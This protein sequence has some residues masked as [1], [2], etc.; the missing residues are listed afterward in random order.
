M[1][2][3]RQLVERFSNESPLGFLCK[4]M[5]LGLLTLLFFFLSPYKVS[6]GCG[7]IDRSF[8]GYSFINPQIIQS[9][10]AF[11]PFFLDFKTIHRLYKGQRVEQIKGN[12]QEWYER[13][14]E[15]P[16]IADLQYIIYQASIDEM[17]QLRT[18]IN[19]RSIPLPYQM[20][21]NTFARYL[22]RNKCYETIDYLIFAKRCEPYVTRVDPWDEP[23]RV[24]DAMQRL[25]DAGRK[26]FM[27]TESHYIRLR[28]AY[29]L[30]R[31]AH[32]AKNYEQALELYDYLM[33]KTDNSPSIIEDW[34]LGHKAGAMMALGRNVEASYL[35]SRIFDRSPSKRESAFRSFNIQ[36]DEEWQQCLLLCEDDH[37]R[38]MLYV[39]RAN[40]VHS[41]LVEE[42]EN[43]Y[44]L[45]PKNENLELLLLKE[46]Q[47]LEKDLLGYEFND[48]KRHNKRYHKLPRPQAGELV[49]DLQDFTRKV[50]EEQKVERPEF[51]KLAE[52][53][54][55]LLAGNYYFA[56]KTFE[57]V[58]PQITNDTL[59]EQ[60]QVFNL[61]LTVSSYTEATDSV[62]RQAE[63]ITR[64]R[65]YSKYEDFTDF[66]DDK[67]AS[68]Y[69]QGEYK[70]KSFRMRYS[71]DDLK[72]NPQAEII[73]DLLVVCNKPQRN[74]MEKRMVDK[75][76]GTTIKSDLLDL[77]ATILMNQFQLEAALEVYKQMDRVEWDNYGVFN[78]FVDQNLEGMV[79]CVHR[80]PLPDTVTVYNKGTLIERLL[81]ME[82][83]ARAETNPNKAALIYYRLGIA[84]YNM[85]YF[86]YAWRVMD[87]FR[88]GASLRR[89]KLEDG[90]N[91][92]PHSVY[93]YGNKENFDL[94]RAAYFFEKAHL[95]TTN[96]N[97]AARSI[98]MLAKCEQNQYYV[99]GPSGTPRTYQFYDLLINNYQE[100]SF[101]ERIIEECKYLE[102]YATR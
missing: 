3:W 42:M 102:A 37:E 15:I 48:N 78:P 11:A 7:P 2:N 89:W 30:I 91:I 38:A 18:A 84:F 46:M 71:L 9:R 20:A 77:K 61:A 43:I 68:L 22:D 75:E 6:K 94:N 16:K 88:S 57:E 13:F 58:A 95:L 60:L 49:I 34:I 12:L 81:E 24:V 65:L 62:E 56:A 31:L 40:G 8:R 29:Q 96:A 100:T 67:M 44:A 26:A 66:L 55:E 85:S 36:T 80:C 17:R 52:G 47:K 83:E 5:K 82:Y 69:Q 32:Y 98:F 76:D 101:Y 14:C 4:P 73:E 72:P 21:G 33:P 54:L 1:K 97:I 35:F 74:R 92:V 19:S 93:P 99:K 39:L 51:W 41:N 90:D 25:I 79:D 45:D 53:Y 59:K 23:E 64:S 70:G 28:Y 63:R 27:K 86:G 87:Y 10:I 50:Q